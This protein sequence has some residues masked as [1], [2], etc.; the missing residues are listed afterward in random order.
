MTPLRRPHIVIVGA[1]FGG[2]WTA[3]ALGNAP[4]DVTLIDRGNYHTF[5]PLL[6][7]VGA[8][9]LEPESIA[10]PVRN[11]VRGRDNLRFVL[12]E[13]SD[14]DLD[15][16]TVSAGDVTLDYDYLVLAT[17]STTNYFGVPGAA[18]HAFPLR[19]LT[20]GVALRNHVLTCLERAA[21]ESDPDRRQRLLTFVVVG[22]GPTGVEYSGAL[23]ELVHTVA[24]RDF[25]MLEETPAQ[26]V[27]LEAG[28][29]PLGAL[30]EPL[31]VYAGRRL[32]RMGVEVRT[33]AK[34]ASVGPEAVELADGSRVPAETVV[35]TAGVRAHPVVEAWGFPTAAAGR[36]PVLPTLQLADRPEVY[37]VGDP[38]AA[39]G[40]DG[41]PLPML[42][43]VALQMGE[44]AARNLRR[45]LAGQAP[46]PFVYRDRGTLA[47]I[48]RNAAVAHLFGRN[49]TGFPAWVIWLGFHL[50]SLIGFRNRLAAL[51]SWAW[52][53]LFSERVVRLILRGPDR[54]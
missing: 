15:A 8:A 19:T 54:E 9:E 36:V 51:S 27:V 37:V 16:R 22:S 34:V 5:F 2:L 45:Q 35:W 52:D 26:V 31:G 3:K 17:G 14:I 23:A 47:V 30:P 43:S 6:Y 29:R 20:D 48:G 46:Q 33:E 1:G 40:P 39:P 28:A 4:A 49:L 41:R 53:Y 44:W 18:Q 38:A 24:K 25:P 32:A 11:I 10:Y 7:Q 13:V 42:A 50:M 12:G 21:V